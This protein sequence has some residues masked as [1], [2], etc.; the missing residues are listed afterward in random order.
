ML[1]NI[2]HMFVRKYHMEK[3]PQ[4]FGDIDSISGGSYPFQKIEILE[5]YF[6]SRMSGLIRVLDINLSD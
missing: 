6:N 2:A 1:K 4:G 5:P 3:S